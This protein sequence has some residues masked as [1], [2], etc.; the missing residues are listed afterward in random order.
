MSDML[1]KYLPKGLFARTFLI[2]VVPVLVLQLAISVVFF[3][4]HWSK[5]TE[6]LATAV[7]GEVEAIVYEVNNHQGDKARI[8]HILQ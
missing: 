5:M 3:E 6:R 7:A 1:K 8:D 4:R 2:V